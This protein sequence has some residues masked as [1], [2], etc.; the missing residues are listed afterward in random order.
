M[1]EIL[2]ISIRRSW[3]LS[4]NSLFSILDKDLWVEDSSRFSTFTS[5]LTW[6]EPISTSSFVL[7]FLFWFDPF[8][9]EELC[10]LAWGDSLRMLVGVLSIAICSAAVKSK[11]VLSSIDVSAWS[12][13][14]STF[15]CSLLT[16]VRP[17][18]NL[19]VLLFSSTNS[20]LAT[21]SKSVLLFSDLDVTSVS[22]LLC[23][24]LWA[25]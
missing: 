12:Y 4:S 23:N 10:E 14:A 19:L 24:L 6:R 17:Y 25:G 2:S 1:S 21:L 3:S 18:V 8:S 11:S 7:T 22:A 13:F 5:L 20:S 16:I 9:F 15:Y